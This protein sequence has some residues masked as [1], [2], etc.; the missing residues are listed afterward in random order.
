MPS[1]SR[2]RRQEPLANAVIC[3]YSFNEAA[4]QA[5]APDGLCD[6]A[7]C[8][9]FYLPLHKGFVEGPGV[10][11]ET[12]MIAASKHSKTEYGISFPF[13]AI[14]MVRYDLS[15]EAA[16][17]SVSRYWA[18]RFYHYGFVTMDLG[19]SSKELK[20]VLVILKMVK[21]L[22]APLAKRDGR[23]SY[24][25]IAWNEKDT[26]AVKGAV[27]VMREVLMPDFIIVHGHRVYLGQN[28]SPERVSA[29]TNIF[30]EKD[31]SNIVQ[32]LGQAVK[33][34]RELSRMRIPAALALSVSMSAYAYNLKNV[35]ELPDGAA[36]MFQEANY[37]SVLPFVAYEHVCGYPGDFFF[38]RERYNST[39]HVRYRYNQD[40]RLLFWDTEG[41]L[42]EKLCRIKRNS[43]D[44]QYTVA[45]YD[46]DWDDHDDTC[47][48]ANWFG[49]YSRVKMVRVLSEFFHYGFHTKE[50]EIDC[51]VIG[52]EF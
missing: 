40:G 15:S 47:S 22:V 29:P 9:Q 25:A 44:V 17:T 3:H 49:A 36:A 12:F 42:R 5:L 27:K 2:A 1:P 16:P 6:Y 7:F 28:P 52:D 34:L 10:D 13:L 45:A 26:S 4:V 46:L 24:T 51:L 8:E 23:P 20:H 30:V 38:Y 43:T 37:S 35:G 41:S 48:F 11:Q 21:K 19:R 33:S 50:D 39:Y 18:M 31:A 14:S 32:T